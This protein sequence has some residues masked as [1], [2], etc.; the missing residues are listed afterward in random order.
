MTGLILFVNA[1]IT[2]AIR[3]RYDDTT[4]RFDYNE[5][6]KITIIVRFD[7]RFDCNTTMTKN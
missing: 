6:I 3:L 7:V 5:V 4:I 2:I 1:Y